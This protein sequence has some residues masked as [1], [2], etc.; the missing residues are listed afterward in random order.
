MVIDM[1]DPEDIILIY[2]E[3][4]ETKAE[5]V[6]DPEKLK[7]ELIERRISLSEWIFCSIDS[8]NP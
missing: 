4:G 3:K 6:K 2:K 8:T 1:F 7:D 5:R